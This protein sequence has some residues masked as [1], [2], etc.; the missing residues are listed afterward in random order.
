MKKLIFIIFSLIL[1]S[2][3]TKEYTLNV[4]VSPSE[5][6]SVSPSMGTYKDGSSVSVVATPSGEYEFS[7]WSGD[8][9]GTSNVLNFEMN[10]NKNIVAQFVKR[11]Y[12]LTINTQ[13]EGTVSEQLISSGKSTDYSSGSVVKL[14]ANP[15]AGYYFSGWSGAITGDTNPV[16]VNID[17]P[18]TITAKFEKKSYALEVKI[19]GEGTVSEEIVVTGKSTDYLYGTTVRLKPTP[20]EGWDFIRWEEDHTG[21]E[22]PLEITINGPTNITANFEYGILLESVGR[23]KVKKKKGTELPPIIDQKSMVVSTSIDVSSIIFNKDYSYILN[24]TT[25][26]ISGTFDVI[27]NTE[28]KLINVGVITN[29][30]ITGAQIN[31]TINVLGVIKFDVSGTKDPL[32]QAGKVS[33]PDTNFEQALIDSGYDDALDTYIDFLTVLDITQLDLSNRSI[34]DFSGLEYFTNLEDLNLGGNG[35]SQIPL[36]NFT[37]LSTLNLSGNSFNQLD[38]SLNSQLGSLNISGNP[39]LT[40]VRVESSLISNIPSG[41]IYDST[42]SFELECDC[43]TLSL[44][45]GSIDQTF[46]SGDAIQPITFDFGGT[47]VLVNV[48]Q[49]IPSGLATSISNNTLTISGTPD[50]SNYSYS[51]SVYTTGGNQNCNQ[52][53]QTITINRDLDSPIINLISGSL[54]QTT[55]QGSAIQPIE[56]TYGGAATDLSISGLPTNLFSIVKNINAY[57]IQGSLRDSYT[58]RASLPFAGFT[59]TG[60]I[61]TISDGGCQE[62]TRTIKITV[63]SAPGTTTGGGTT[64]GTTTGGTTGGTTYNTTTSNTGIYFENGTCKCPNASVGETAVINGVTYTVVDDSTMITSRD[65]IAAGNVNLCTTLVTN[66]SGLF[67][68]KTSFN[69]NINFWDTSNVTDMN[70]M[71]YYALSFNQNISNWDTSNVINMH[72]MFRLTRDFNQ[73]IGGWNTSSVKVMSYMF[74]ETSSFNQDIGN[75]NTSSLVEGNNLSGGGGV[76]YMFNN[77]AAF[78][79]DLSGWC[80]SNIQSEPT[81]FAT[82]S[83]LTNAN[84][85]VWGRAC[86]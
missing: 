6:G 61:T 50:L 5:G 44:T 59:Y 27:S 14:T 11:K 42:T 45:S 52:V 32:F 58:I 56:L 80:V 17:K 62:E 41:W 28:I 10:G 35:I 13:G 73:N 72:G 21:E 19:E 54:V 12:S 75:W 85:P 23:W 81:G 43:P 77:A 34:S 67:N 25:G 65:Q 29:I 49:T 38:L 84:K 37:K 7:R 78:N 66:M 83:A 82:S 69:S 74:A 86:D 79:Q 40:C 48:D 22:N 33:I 51:F 57:S 24:T 15:S 47:G 55:S 4:T 76:F 63:Q 2:S 30:S 9:S 71:F 20:S 1:Y 8:E 39:N 68:S 36:V 46:C 60:S 70:A 64:G 3:C 18:K 53:S 31:F 26:Q 16:E